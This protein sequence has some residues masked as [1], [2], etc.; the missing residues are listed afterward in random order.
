MG[1]TPI[2][3]VRL[4]K[5]RGRAYGL[6]WQY[7]QRSGEV[8]SGTSVRREAE[9]AAGRLEERLQAG[10]IPGR[11][12]GVAIT[13]AEFRERYE[14]EWLDGMSRGS[15]GNWKTAADHFEEI[16]HPHLLAD[17][18][19]STLS[20]FRAGL[21]ALD[22]KP[23]SSASYFSSLR[24][25]LG[26]AADVVGLIDRAPTIRSRR[27]AKQSAVMR[28]RPVTLE[29]FERM[30][31]VAPEVRSNT[32]TNKSSGSCVVSGLQGSESMSSAA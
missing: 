7:G 29:E 10:V 15:R 25:G 24:A 19:K 11:S 17:I 28:S 5:Y 1:K 13:W 16:C 32:I 27:K 2:I 22:I 18:N 31:A 6:I 14:R 8:S 21:D 9:R 30:I 12:D 3:R 4:H 23:T 26:W 20:R